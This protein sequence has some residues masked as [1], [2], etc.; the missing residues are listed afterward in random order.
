MF[1][2]KESKEGDTVADEAEWIKHTLHPIN[3]RLI[4]SLLPK[5]RLILSLFPKMFIIIFLI[6]C[7]YKID[8]EKYRFF[9]V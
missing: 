1:S 5:Y 8:H 7:V 4:L 2:F 9:Y 3:H 6:L